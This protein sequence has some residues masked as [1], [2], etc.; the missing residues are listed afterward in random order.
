MYRDF[1][2]FALKQY[3][4]VDEFVNQYFSQLEPSEE[5]SLKVLKL[6]IQW[7]QRQ[8]RNDLVA[9]LQQR[10]F[11]LAE[12]KLVTQQQ[13]AKILGVAKLNNEVIQLN[14]ETV[15]KELA[16]Q[17]ELNRIH[18]V[19]IVMATILILILLIYLFRT[20][21]KNKQRNLFS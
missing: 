20:R 18:L 19:V 14:A 16:Y 5:S 21:R 8:A 13:A 7:Y 3:D 4:C 9:P 15:E 17:N 10:Y 11:E 12:K 2:C 1:S 6:L